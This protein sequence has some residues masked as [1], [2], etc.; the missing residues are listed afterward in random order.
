MLWII[1]QIAGSEATF[2]QIAAAFV[3]LNMINALGIYQIWF[4]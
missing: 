3:H 2:M 4:L 1:Q